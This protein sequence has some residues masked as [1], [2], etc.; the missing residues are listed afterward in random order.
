MSSAPR[1]SLRSR[2]ERHAR[3][4]G[5][6]AAISMGGVGALVVTVSCAEPTV[7]LLLICGATVAVCVMT[8]ALSANVSGSMLR[9][10]NGI[11]DKVREF[12]RGNKAARA[13]S[14]GLL[15]LRQLS[16]QINRMA[17]E[18]ET[19]LQEI[20]AE[21]RRESHFVSDVS[22]ELRTPLTS[23]RGAAETLLEGDVDPEDQARFLNMIV[24]ESSR[25]SR[26]AEDLMTLQRIEGG[27][28]EIRLSRFSLGLAVNRAAETLGPLMEMRGVDFEVSGEPAEV[29]GDIDRIQQVVVNLLDNASRVVGEGG[30]VWIEFSSVDRHELGPLLHEGG[31]ADV[32]RFAVMSV[33]DNGPGIPVAKRAHLFDRFY[34]QQY[35]RDR[36]SGGSGLGLSIVK[37]IVKSHNGAIRL[38]D[39]SDEIRIPHAGAEPPPPAFG[40]CF[41]VYLPIPPEPDMQRLGSFA[42]SSP[43]TGLEERSKRMRRRLQP[44]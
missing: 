3:Q 26:L 7:P 10:L 27:T 17:E 23:I 42:S 20:H 44:R 11:I 40:A 8:W 16:E 24:S 30:R 36:K 2:I 31:V 41:M 13:W 32:E 1:N 35:S 5:L 38:R 43:T 28:G 34:R 9:D 37:A 39:G 25:L 15:E 6:F 18:G 33:Y 12:N 29:L 14:S 4:M 21:D 22:H 19:A